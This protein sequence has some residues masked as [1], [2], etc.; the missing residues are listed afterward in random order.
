MCDGDLTWSPGRHPKGAAVKSK[1]RSTEIRANLV[2]GAVYLHCRR[3][4][5]FSGPF[6][7]TYTVD[8]S[9]SSVYKFFE[10]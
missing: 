5:T 1:G 3:D 8:M 9:T 2:G 6:F 10:V 7:E 4:H